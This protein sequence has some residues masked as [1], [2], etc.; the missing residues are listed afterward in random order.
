LQRQFDCLVLSLKKGLIQD[1]I[2]IHSGSGHAKVD[3]LRESEART[4]ISRDG[5]RLKNIENSHSGYKPHSII[6]INY[7]LI[8]RFKTTTVS[9]HDSYVNL[10]EKE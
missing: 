5:T 6:D 2:F 7:E 3:K 9:L 4:R 8:R 10:S 1:A